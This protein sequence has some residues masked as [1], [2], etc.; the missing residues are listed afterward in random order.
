MIKVWKLV[1]SAARSWGIRAYLQDAMDWDFIPLIPVPFFHYE[2]GTTW[3]ELG[4]GI[5]FLKWSVSIEYHTK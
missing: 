3:K 5:A 4:V 2:R 1:D